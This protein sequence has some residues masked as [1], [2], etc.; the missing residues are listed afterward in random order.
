M[1]S[2]K[3]G[4]KDGSG[5]GIIKP[6]PEDPLPWRSI[7]MRRPCDPNCTV[8]TSIVDAKGHT[9]DFD[10]E[11][12]GPFAVTAANMF[13]KLVAQLVEALDVLDTWAMGGT[14][15]AQNIQATLDE[16]KGG[17]N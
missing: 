9:V 2:A 3:T 1:A 8:G 7:D 14:Q 13:H 10:P 17:D 11:E 16:A 6:A 5:A 12:T 4:G 15:L